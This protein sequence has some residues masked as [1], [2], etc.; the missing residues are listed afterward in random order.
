[1]GVK[2]P[3]GGVDD[4]KYQKASFPEGSQGVNNNEMIFHVFLTQLFLAF[5]KKYLS[6]I[7]D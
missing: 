1:V 6:L 3:Y 2:N 5:T 4:L 7:D